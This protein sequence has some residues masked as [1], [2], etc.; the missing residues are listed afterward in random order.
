MMGPNSLKF[1][2]NRSPACLSRQQ[3]FRF[4][5]GAA[6]IVGNR[7]NPACPGRFGPLHHGRNPDITQG[8]WRAAPGPADRQGSGAIQAFPSEFHEDFL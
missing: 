1:I 7:R 6:T 5:A 2:S 8:G 3:P 4:L